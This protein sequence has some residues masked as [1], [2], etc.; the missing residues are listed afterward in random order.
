M[1]C[2]SCANI[3][4]IS[5][6]P[7]DKESPVLVERYSSNNFQ[8]H[9]KDHEITLSFNEWIRLDNPVGNISISPPTEFPPEYK[10]KGKRLI[11]KFD[12]KEQL[13]ENTTYTILFGESV[14]DITAGNVQ[15]NLS[16]VFS[17]GDYVDS[18]MIRGKVIDAF[19][20]KPKDKTIVSLYKLLDDTAFQK[21]KPFYFSWTD[22]AGRF[23]LKNL[24][25]GKYK[26]YA[27]EDKNQNYFF[28]QSNESFAFITESIT[29]SD[30]IIQDFQ[31]NV[32]VHSPPVI[33]KERKILE[34]EARIYFN[35]NPNTIELIKEISDSIYFVHLN[36]S[37]LI[38]NQG[39]KEVN[40]ILQYDHKMDSLK[41]PA[42]LHPLKDSVKIIRLDKAILKPGEQA[43][44]I[45]N[46]PIINI[47][48]DSL[49]SLDNTTTINRSRIDSQ[50]NRKFY[51]DGS[52]S[53]NKPNRL[54]ILRNAIKG[55]HNSTNQQDTFTF[56][57]LDKSALSRL[58]IN[59]E[60]LKLNSPYIFQLLNG[61]L[62]SEELKFVSTE[63]LKK[64]FFNN[65]FPGK[66]RVRI[67]YDGN[68]NGTWD[69]ADYT[70][71]KQAEQ[72]W[73][74]DLPDLRADW[75]VDVS[76]NL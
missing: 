61:D 20:K 56:R 27:L 6:G 14:K 58:N 18:L 24:S 64:M 55:L 76:L 7:E 38:Y 15:R 47:T 75:D 8:T 5:G 70:S 16:Y 13:K 22:T 44:F 17:T 28:D 69:P 45:M 63:T 52:F 9:F 11:I 74:F 25:P 51:L 3:Q 41:I 59:L 2:I 73:Y 53:P 34:G 68:R 65:L 49:Q 23:I 26:L 30:T 48:N 32:S 19:T 10:L 42:V 39:N 50:D 43:A 21:T 62:I 36:D 29:I 60:G 71:K 67:I 40:C 46:Y 31:L 66:Y 37:V 12:K 4:S 72:I 1:Y 33:I 54:V 57:Y 35:T